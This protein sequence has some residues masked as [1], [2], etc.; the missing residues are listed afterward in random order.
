MKAGI[1]LALQDLPGDLI[2]EILIHQEMALSWISTKEEYSNPV[3]LYT[4]SAAGGEWLQATESQQ[5]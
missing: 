2:W 4:P 1:P 3:D 5:H